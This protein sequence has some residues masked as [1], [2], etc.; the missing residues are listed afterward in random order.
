MAVVY[1][2][3]YCEF[4]GFYFANLEK[5][6]LAKKL[7]LR[8]MLKDKIHE[9]FKHFQDIDCY[10]RA[11]TKLKGQTFVL[12]INFDFKNKEFLNFLKEENLT[13]DVRNRVKLKMNK[14][15]NDQKQFVDSYEAVDIYGKLNERFA[16]GENFTEKSIQKEIENLTVE[17]LKEE[18]K[19]K[20]LPQ[21]T[22][23]AINSSKDKNYKEILENLSDNYFNYFEKTGEQNNFEHKVETKP[24][25]KIKVNNLTV[26]DFEKNEQKEKHIK[27]P[28]FMARLYYDVSGLTEEEK[29]C[30]A[31]FY[32]GTFKN[33][34]EKR[35]KELGYCN[36]NY[37]G[38]ECFNGVYDTLFFDNLIFVDLFGN[39]EKLFEKETLAKNFKEIVK[40]IIKKTKNLDEEKIKNLSSLNLNSKEYLENFE[41]K[42]ENFKFSTKYGIE[43]YIIESFNLTKEPFSSKYFKVNEDGELLDLEDRNDFFE[44]FKNFEKNFNFFLENE[45]KYIDL[46]VANKENKHKKN[47][48]EKLEFYFYANVLKFPKE[49]DTNFYSKERVVRKILANIFYENFFKK[50]LV[51][52]GLILKFDNFDLSLYLPENSKQEV[53]KYLFGEFK[54]KFKKFK[55]SEEDF[56]YFKKQAIENLNLDIE[57]TKES[58]KKTEEFLKNE[59]KIK[60]LAEENKLNVN[61]VLKNLQKDVDLREKMLKDKEKIENL[62]GFKNYIAD[63]KKQIKELEENKENLAFFEEKI[64]EKNK[65]FVEHQ[66]KFLKEYEEFLEKI[67][68]IE[69]KDVLSLFKN[70]EFRNISKLEKKKFEI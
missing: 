39:D 55:P 56:E 34:V 36:M 40:E 26:K 15:F 53:E 59:K 10:N 46:L 42:V 2:I 37:N 48:E 65:E 60:N 7:I 54:E 51:D 19:E 57:R 28:K 24:F 52:K 13:Q 35:L 68:E 3:E 32:N 30:L 17:D 38:K 1:N 67:K 14:L 18:I 6:S 20:I 12:N 49:Q 4:N 29:Y 27:N 21:N 11:E 45:P 43:N 62:E 69:F 44:K 50:N 58:I 63:S 5:D 70:L 66:Q 64:K 16:G 9:K 31:L 33:L 22:M 41:Q 23:V 25:R 61:E 8:E 47:N